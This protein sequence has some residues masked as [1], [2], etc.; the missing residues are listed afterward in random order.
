MEQSLRWRIW[1]FSLNIS[2]GVWIFGYNLGVLNPSYQEVSHALNW[3]SNENFYLSLFQTLL[4]IGC[5]IGS[6][7][8]SYI[9]NTWGR[10]KCV[11]TLSGFTILGSLISIFPYNATF[12]IG[13]IFSGIA[14]GMGLSLA[15]FYIVEICPSKMK[16][17]VGSLIHLNLALGLGLSY[18]LGIA[19]PTHK[20][21]SIM[22]HWW[23]FMYLFPSF[24]AVYILYVFKYVHKLDTAKFYTLTLDFDKAQAALEYTFGEAS[25]PSLLQKINIEEDK[26]VLTPYKEL[27]CTKKY[28]LM[29]TVSIVLPMLEQLCG[30]N[31]A[32]FYST[33][34]LYDV[35]GDIFISR[36]LTACIGISKFFATFGIFF[37]VKH[38]GRRTILIYS[39][40]AMGLLCVAFALFSSVLNF[41][42]YASTIVLGLH[43]VVYTSSFAAI[44]WVYI[45]ES[46]DQKLVPVAVCSKFSF[47]CLITFSFP[48]MV[49]LLGIDYVFYFFAFCSCVGFV[50]GKLSLVETKGLSKVEIF[51]AYT[52]SS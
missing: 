21:S 10:R 24:I 49:Q 25:N 14:S 48:L 44:L 20:T 46:V 9:A 42:V 41:G 3:G 4:P 8:T 22:K 31:A 47:L 12:G 27:L 32:T 13:R 51:N 45:G 1:F 5:I 18:C 33:K 40:L 11:F 17:T 19:L 30:I 43:V 35:S 37:L 29:L 34:I 26:N 36:V 23:Q 39:L 52:E 50:W 6:L 28:R 16:A 2:L 7:S 15:P 38:L